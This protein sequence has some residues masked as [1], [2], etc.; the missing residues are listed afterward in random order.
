MGFV[1]PDLLGV[2]VVVINTVNCWCLLQKV[3]LISTGIVKSCFISLNHFDSENSFGIDNAS[4][5][6]L[7]E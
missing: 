2:V 3:V 4:R 5:A 6:L 7:Q 1:L